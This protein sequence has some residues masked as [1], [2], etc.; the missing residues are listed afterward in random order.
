MKK[1][2][3]EDRKSIIN[4]QSEIDC[5]YTAAKKAED[6]LGKVAGELEKAREESANKASIILELEGKLQE[7]HRI[8]A[9]KDRQIEE[10]ENN[11]RKEGSIVR[12]EARYV[13]MKEFLD[14]KG[15]SWRNPPETV[16]RDFETYMRITGY[17]LQ[18]DTVRLPSDAAVAGAS[19]QGGGAGS[20]ADG[21]GDTMDFLV[22]PTEDVGG[23][24][25]DS[26]L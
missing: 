22:D 16:V 25:R 20:S 19:S 3:E 24:G 10:I 8:G 21:D 26:N 14:F 18:Y 6:R 17:Q 2:E 4:Q 23:T 1:K 15:L 7:A 11:F 5:A 13:L 12:E 9:E